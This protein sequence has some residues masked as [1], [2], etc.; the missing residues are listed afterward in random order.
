[1]LLE[2]PSRP[3]PLVSG[4]SRADTYYAPPS[5]LVH[6]QRAAD[7]YGLPLALPPRPLPRK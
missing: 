1:M 4:Y 6:G 5:P 7:V 3:P 2:P